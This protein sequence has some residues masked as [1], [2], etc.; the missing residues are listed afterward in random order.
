MHSLL[1]MNKE[2]DL[3]FIFSLCWGGQNNTVKKFIPYVPSN[4][5]HMQIRI[6][7]S[8]KSHDLHILITPTNVYNVK[9]R[10]LC[11]QVTVILKS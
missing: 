11:I 3:I 8:G 2:N 7:N 5:T 1:Y 6:F 10:F 9:I 4:D